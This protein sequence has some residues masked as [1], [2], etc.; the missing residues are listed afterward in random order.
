M[1]K[2]LAILCL[3]NGIYDLILGLM[4]LVIPNLAANMFGVALDPVATMI[5]QIVGACLLAFAVGLFAAYRNID[6][7]L[8]IPF[9]KIIAHLL[10]VVLAVYYHLMGF[11]P[12]LFLLFVGVDGFFGVVYLFGF[13][14]SKDISFGAAFA[15]S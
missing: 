3:L 2:P 7:L 6:G 1:K 4:F 8:I 15:S 10:T 13:L 11:V 5:A 14:V 12:L 9:I